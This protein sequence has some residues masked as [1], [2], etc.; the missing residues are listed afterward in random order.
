VADYRPK[1]TYDKKIKKQAD[2]LSF[3][4]ERTTDILKELGKLKKHQLL[5]GF[6][7]ETNHVE[8]YAKKKL[9][10]KNLDLIVANNVTSEG[11]GFGTDTNIVTIF[12]RELNVIE[13]PLMSKREVARKL[14]NKVQLLLKGEK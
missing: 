3:E 4:M 6:A 1:I 14:L 8:E 5:V 12:D 13:L 7:A 2:S 9:E 11:A 10:A